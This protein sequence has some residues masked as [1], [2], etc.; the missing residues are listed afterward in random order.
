MFCFAQKIFGK[1]VNI[2]NKGWKYAKN[3]L[4][5]FITRKNDVVDLYGLDFK[6]IVG[7]EESPSEYPDYSLVFLSKSDRTYFESYLHLRKDIGLRRDALEKFLN[8]GVLIFLVLAGGDIIGASSL[9]FKR[10][11]LGGFY[12]DFVF[13]DN[14]VYWFNLYVVP[15]FRFKGIAN[16]LCKE[17]IRYCLRNK[18]SYC[19]GAIYPWNTVIKKFDLNHG[20]I[21]LGSVE[22]VYQFFLRRYSSKSKVKNNKIGIFLDIGKG[23]RLVI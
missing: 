8:D 16:L 17:M 21:Y 11:P 18:Y 1:L 6:N 14:Y 10:H 9:A 12:A 13:P 5:K 3:G 23:K 22:I 4:K 19:F 15:N 20:F 2:K 7:E